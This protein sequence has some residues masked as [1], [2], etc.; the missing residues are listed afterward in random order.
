MSD[1]GYVNLVRHLTRPT[2]T[3][4][5]ETLQA[6]IAHYLARPP[7]P[8][9]GTPTALTASVLGSALFRPHRHAQLA[10][11]ALAFRHAVHLR[12]G[13]LKEA[14]RGDGG[15][16]L[17]AVLA[18]EEHSGRRVAARLGRWCRDVWA[19]CGGSAPLARLACV[20]GLLLGLEDWEA[21]LKITEREARV[22]VKA[23]EEVVLAVAEVVDAYAPDPSGWGV[24][25]KRSVEARAEH[26]DP[27]GLAITLTAQCAPL[28]AAQRLQALPLPAILDVL[29]STI[30]QTFRGG[31]FL[32]GASTSFTWNTEGKVAA[33]S[34]PN[35][36]DTIRQISG[37]PYLAS[38]ASYAKFTSLSLTN[39]VESR[40]VPGWQTIQQ[41]LARFK[42][43]TAR[44]EDD[45][46]KC[47]LAS[48]TGDEQFAGSSSR[49]LTKTTWSI[50]KTLLFTALMISQSVLTAVVFVSQPEDATAAPS[51]FALALEILHILSNLSFVMPQFGGVAST[52]EGL[53][54]LKRAFYMALD[55]L[56]ES[57]TQSR[58]F[59]EELCERDSS[60]SKG[61]GPETIPR[62]LLNAKKAF[63]LACAEQLV[64]VLPELTIRDQVYPMC[65]P[66]LWDTTHRETYESAHSVMLSIF[67][68]HAKGKGAKSKAPGPAFAEKV[69]PLYSRC[70]IENSPDGHLSTAQLCLAYAAL[71]RS[72]GS[73]GYGAVN[74]TTSNRTPSDAYPHADALAWYCVDA[75]LDAIRRTSTAT[76]LILHLHLY[77]N[78]Q[79][80]RPSAHLHRLHLALVATAASVSLTLLPRLLTEVAAIIIAVPDDAEEMRTE[81]TDALFKIVAEEVG[82]AEKAYAMDWWYEH[83]DT[84]ARGRAPV[85]DPVFEGAEAVPAAGAPDIVSRL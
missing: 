70:L 80:P 38:M 84:L 25:F 22:R 18:P 16:S 62:P 51:P 74:T 79:T 39:L 41:V 5:P 53:P 21:E 57:E 72:A 7:S 40:P 45:W 14:S 69:V 61:K 19:G 33:S 4:S 60:M 37:S 49:D 17:S 54:E 42:Q 28:V 46:V 31:A 50:L 85:R 71:V 63:A 77:S 23:E 27:L 56:S 8:L 12:V 20:V 44:L 43:L 9:P 64:P 78:T 75:L 2:S 6:S 73:F 52:S 67:A 82:D 10:A 26:E 81:L 76:V 36:S 32:V 13:V 59:V 48:V 65:F 66:H 24:D 30:E 15:F 68:S 58:R 3:L 83:R 29:V 34:P 1:R 35:F 55:V 47:A 11:L